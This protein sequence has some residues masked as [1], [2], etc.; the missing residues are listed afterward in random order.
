MCIKF[1]FPLQEAD[2]LKSESPNAML[3]R[4]YGLAD[5]EERKLRLFGA[6]CCRRIWDLLVDEQSRAVVEALER[7]VDGRETPGR[8]AVFA[9][10]AEDLRALR[11][12]RGDYSSAANG[13]I[14]QAVNAIS[15]LVKGLGVANRLGPPNPHSDVGFLSSSAASAR[16]HVPGEWYPGQ[17]AIFRPAFD[18]EKSAHADLLREILGN[19]FRPRPIDPSWLTPGVRDLAGWIDLSGDFDGL[20]ALGDAL[21]EAGCDGPEILE[22]C[23]RPG[24]HVRGCWA[25]DAVLGRGGPLNEH[26]P[27]PGRDHRLRL[28][29]SRGGRA[30]FSRRPRVDPPG[31]WKTI[32]RPIRY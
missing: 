6:A 27:A 31:F 9:Q 25:L 1:E 13:S 12:S 32:L 24:G 19:P 23:R 18:A 8:M 28:V 10:A 4:G 17:D 7:F 20:P 29:N 14:V 3:V 30:A 16:A 21:E 5:F 26:D 11:L 22:H 15:Y 2:W